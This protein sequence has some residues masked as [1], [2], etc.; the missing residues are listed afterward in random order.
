MLQP[1]FGTQQGASQAI[2]V[3]SELRFDGHALRPS[4]SGTP[5][6]E[7]RDHRWVVNGERY[8]RLDC[9]GNAML[10]ATDAHGALGRV[11]GPFEHLSSHNGTL[12]ADRKKFAT[13]DDASGL[14]TLEAA[15]AIRCPVLVARSA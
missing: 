12:Y 11:F 5:V 15:P 8:F 14:W 3:F 6:A 10:H 1:V 7:Q 4:A 9:E 2:G 13:L